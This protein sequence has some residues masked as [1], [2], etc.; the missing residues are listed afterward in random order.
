MQEFNTKTII[1]GAGAVGLAVARELSLKK[2]ET[3]IIEEMGEFGTLTSSRNSG[4]IHAGIYYKTNSLKSKFCVEGNNL[5]YE[6]AKQFNIPH[7][8]TKKILVASSEDQINEIDRIKDQGSTNGVKN[9]EKLSEV[10]VSNLEPLIKCKEGLLIPSTGIIDSI[11][12]MRSLVGEIE[13]NGNM[14]AYNCSVE[15]VY[16]DNENFIVIVK[17]IKDKEIYKLKSK[18]F[19]NAAGLKASDLAKKIEGL[20]DKFIPKT[21]FAKGNY[22]SLSK[23]PGINHLV[24]PIPE[25]FGLGIHLTLELDNSIKFGPDVE[26]VENMDNYEVDINRKKSFV[27]AIKKYLP[28]I[29]VNLLSPSYSGIRPITNKKD[30]SMRDF[31]ISDFKQHRIRNLFNLYGIESPGL[32]ASLAIAKYLSK[33]IIK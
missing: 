14:I 10:Q 3:I 4:V 16:L 18:N 29:D 8:N 11:S 17:N 21:F 28:S 23:N 22:F 2:M 25:G 5:L 13:E 19:I 7:K 27:E 30:K 33:Q 20:N 15:K 24:Y 26:W 31:E 32:T 9:I 12:Y 6:Y 1:V